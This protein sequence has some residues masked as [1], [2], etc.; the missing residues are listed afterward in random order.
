MPKS[1]KAFL[2]FP[3]NGWNKK[4]T[5]YMKKKIELKV[6]KE[7]FSKKYYYSIKLDEPNI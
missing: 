6:L 7:I 2:L 1:T 5:F 4:N 3:L